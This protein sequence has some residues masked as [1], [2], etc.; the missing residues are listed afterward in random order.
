ME[1]RERSTQAH[2]HPMHLESDLEVDLLAGPILKEAEHVLLLRPDAALLDEIS[3][4]QAVLKVS[5]EILKLSVS[6]H[7]VSIDMIAVHDFAVPGA[8]VS[9]IHR[10]MP[11]KAP[12]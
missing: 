5:S 7:L 9:A 8:R 10:N 2:T 1:E 12:C 3:C 4:T 6:Q 11:I